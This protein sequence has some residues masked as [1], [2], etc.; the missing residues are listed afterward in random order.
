MHTLRAFHGDAGIWGDWGFD[1][2]DELRHTLGLEPLP[3]GNDTLLVELQRDCELELV[4]MPAEFDTRDHTDANVVHAGP[5]FEESET[6]L[7]DPL[8]WEADDPTPLVVVGLSSTYMR[9]ESLFERI[10][11]GLS[12]LPVHVLATTGPEL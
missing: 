8:P 10:L 12:A 11:T 2:I 1:E 9:Q 7:F 5:I 6:D 4:A 3:R